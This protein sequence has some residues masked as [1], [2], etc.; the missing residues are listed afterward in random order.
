MGESGWQGLEGSTRLTELSLAYYASSCSDHVS[1]HTYVDLEGQQM[2]A[3]ANIIMSLRTLQA[4]KIELFGTSLASLSSYRRFDGTIT[5]LAKIAAHIRSR[6][7]KV[8]FE[9]SKHGA[10]QH[11]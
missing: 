9:E 11:R 3:T 7:G 4:V 1:E 6:G 10:D 2:Q 8:D 5:Q